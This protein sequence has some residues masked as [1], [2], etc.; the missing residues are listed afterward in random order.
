MTDW[1]PNFHW[2]TDTLAVGGSFAPEHVPRLA[3]EHG[4]G[5]VV[6][7]REE[8]R[9][10]ERLLRAHGIA[11]LHL[12][13]ED[14]CGVDAPHLEQGVRFACEQLDR[15]ARVLVHCQHGIGRS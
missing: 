9:D 14:M 12:P 5:A 1:R 15:G 7:L 8:D 2:I 11:L 13:T 6:D 4:V 3:R 10:D